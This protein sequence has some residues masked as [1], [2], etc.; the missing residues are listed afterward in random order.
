MSGTQLYHESSYM[1]AMAKAGLLRVEATDDF[2]TR[3]SGPRGINCSVCRWESTV[4][5]AFPK[6]L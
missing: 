4:Y 2:L 5:S 6:R 1:T 3:D